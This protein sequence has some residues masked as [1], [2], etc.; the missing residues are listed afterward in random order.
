MIKPDKIITMTESKDEKLI[1]LYNDFIA[2]EQGEL[3]FDI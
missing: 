2:D 3:T 1:N